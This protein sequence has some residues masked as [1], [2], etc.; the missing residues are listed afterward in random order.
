MNFSGCYRRKIRTEL[1]NIFHRLTKQSGNNPA[2]FDYVFIS[3]SE[4]GVVDS[5]TAKDVCQLILERLKVISEKLNT[6]FKLV[7]LLLGNHGRN[8]FCKQ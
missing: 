7:L 4:T 6:P 1:H 5:A 2:H 3:F 8:V